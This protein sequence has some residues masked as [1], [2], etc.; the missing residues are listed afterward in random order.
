[1]KH[2]PGHHQRDPGEIDE[3]RQLLQHDDADDGRAPTGD[4]DR[5]RRHRAAATAVARRSRRD[6]AGDGRDRAASG[7]GCRLLSAFHFL[8][9]A[10]DLSL[11]SLGAPLGLLPLGLGLLRRAFRLGQRCPGLLQ[12]FAGLLPSLVP[13][14]RRLAR[15]RIRAF[16]PPGR[17][18]G[19]D[20]TRRPSGLRAASLVRAAAAAPGRP[21]RRGVSSRPCPALLR[22][23]C[24]GA[25]RV[26]C[27][28]ERSGAPRSPSAGRRRASPRPPLPGP[29]AAA[30]PTGSAPAPLTDP[31]EPAR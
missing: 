8:R 19:R 27:G 16:A 29:R 21:R 15:G 14:G 6:R 4:G 1:M 3:R 23:A 7:V 31:R 5:H 18:P 25:G 17:S 22:S 28:R 2:D 26:A 30:F 11:R 13:R 20:R 10:L 12:A 24:A 9:R